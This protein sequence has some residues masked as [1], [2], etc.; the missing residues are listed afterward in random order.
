MVD[1]IIVLVGGKVS[2]K[3][4]CLH[5]S[6]C[7]ICIFDEAF[8]AECFSYQLRK[9]FF[10]SVYCIQSDFEA[11]IILMS[12]VLSDIHECRMFL[13][14][15]SRGFSFKLSNISILIFSAL[16]SKVHR[17]A[18]LNKVHR[19]ASLSKVHRIAPLSKV[20][21]RSTTAS[22]KFSIRWKL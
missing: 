18:S 11:Q 5:R 2:M 16:L 8:G 17:I 19:I 13:R 20:Q 6:F 7:C 10:G 14:I 9:L 15:P 3:R 21:H 12:S 1:C 4:R 22:F